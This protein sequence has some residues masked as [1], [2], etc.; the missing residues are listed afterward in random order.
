MKTTTQPVY[1]FGSTMSKRVEQAV[2][3]IHNH[4]LLEAEKY[5]KY[6]GDSIYIE[7]A[8]GRG[9]KAG[10][11]EG[12]EQ[13]EKDLAEEQ[14]NLLN[15]ACDARYEQAK[16]DTIERACTWLSRHYDIDLARFRKSMEEEQ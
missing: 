3:K 2:K 16:K 15:K 9:F 6:N 10:F 13:A 11:I 8:Y 14:Y 5:A 1:Q 4:A 12:Y 7:V